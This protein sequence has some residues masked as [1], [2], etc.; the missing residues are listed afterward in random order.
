[1]E[2]VGDQV[3][4]AIVLRDDAELSPDAFVEFL[5]AQRDLSPK[6]WPR[7]VWIAADLPSTATNKILKRDLI[8]LGADP[9]GRVLWKRDGRSFHA[10]GERAITG[11]DR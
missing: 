7:Y 6:A 2:Y 11:T 5:A 10:H 1:D 9:D 8:G 3:M 4:A